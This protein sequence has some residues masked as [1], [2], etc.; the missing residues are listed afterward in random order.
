MVHRATS[1]CPSRTKFR[2]KQSKR[3]RARSL[4]LSSRSR[5]IIDLSTLLHPCERPW[6]VSAREGGTK[7]IRSPASQ[8]ASQPRRNILRVQP[9][10]TRRSKGT[11]LHTHER[12][13]PRSP[14]S[15][16]LLSSVPSPRPPF[17]KPNNRACPSSTYLAV[18]RF[19]KLKS[20]RSTPTIHHHDDGC[21]CLQRARTRRD[22][23]VQSANES[24]TRDATI[25]LSVLVVEDLPEDLAD[26][27][28]IYH[29]VVHINTHTHTYRDTAVR[30]RRFVPFF[31][32]VNADSITGAV[33]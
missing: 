14:P 22:Q 18:S 28:Q 15:S 1:S 32:F 11:V 6:S 24:R 21:V 7:T 30:S 16:V 2:E 5:T 20:F 8:P 23:P 17:Q 10:F 26:V 19:A 4:S 13:H 33:E 31:S 29:R 25:A 9:L 27:M 12:T 3:A